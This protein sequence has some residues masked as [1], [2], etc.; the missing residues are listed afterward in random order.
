VLD[1]TSNMTKNFGMAI[2]GITKQTMLLHSVCQINTNINSVADTEVILTTEFTYM[3]IKGRH[4][5]SR[6]QLFLLRNI[7]PSAIS[8][9]SLNTSTRNVPTPYRM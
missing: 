6:V 8:V 5:G 7:F 4:T 2:V 9:M 3:R 1:Y